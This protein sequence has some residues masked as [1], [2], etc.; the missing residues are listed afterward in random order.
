MYS[1]KLKKTIKNRISGALPIVS[2][3]ITTLLAGCETPQLEQSPIEP[4]ISVAKPEPRVPQPIN[5]SIRDIRY[6]QAALK[7]LN[8]NIGW[9]DGIWG[10][11]SATALQ[12]FEQD[13]GILSAGG[14]LTRANLLALRKTAKVQE[15][16]LNL[17]L[18]KP[19]EPLNIA[20]KLN[21]ESPLEDAPQLILLDKPYPMM[22]KPN[23]FSELIAVLQAGA[24]VYVISTD[25]GWYEI[26]SLD[27][28]RGYI[29]EP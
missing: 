17:P 14:K 13:N 3:L 29:K 23:P 15:S 24:G 16:D 4:K 20:S 6:A 1:Q 28:Q 2:I 7:Q 21:K 11:R 27:E 19:S 22:E 18:E 9:V 10:E 5:A 26:E 8:Y 12:K 25:N